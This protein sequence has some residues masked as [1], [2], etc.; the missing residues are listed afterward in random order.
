MRVALIE[1][2]YMKVVRVYRPNVLQNVDYLWSSLD[3][4]FIVACMEH[5]N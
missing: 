4:E 3:V 5:A 1:A 2:V